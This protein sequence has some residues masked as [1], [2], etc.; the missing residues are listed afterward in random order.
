MI[1]VIANI[2][3]GTGKTTIATNMA[4]MRAQDGADVMLVD[5]DTQHS[6]LDF[7]N[8]R[9]LEGHLP[10]ITCLAVTGP[11]TG[12]ELRKLAPK[13]D[14]IIVDVGGRDTSTLRS[15]LLT[16]D[17][18]AIP[19]LPSQ[20][21]TWATETMDALL[22]EVLGMNGNLNCLTFLNKVD[23]VS[24]A[25]LTREAIQL[26]KN[27]KHM[28]LFPAHLSYRVAFR[29]SVADGLCINEIPGKKDAKAIAELN[30]LYE[31]IFKNA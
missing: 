15:A 28:R 22:G 6:A 16:A 23:P 26:A 1:V 12:A 24:Q 14:D 27:F 25:S 17:I 10:E 19:F 4:I 11:A 29:R 9:E 18:V 30:K 2:K 13:F 5:A 3:G 21:D 31:E 20:Y 7:A 8:V